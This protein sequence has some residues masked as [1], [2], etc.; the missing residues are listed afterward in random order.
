MSEHPKTFKTSW[1]DIS[2]EHVNEMLDRSLLPARG[3]CWRMF[4]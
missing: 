3:S 2:K 1:E 4:T